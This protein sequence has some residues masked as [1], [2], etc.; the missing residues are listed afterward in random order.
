MNG[1]KFFLDTNA[2][3]AL[4][5]GNT[6][7]EQNLSEALWIGTSAICVLEFLSFRSLLKED[8]IIFDIFLKRIEVIEVPEEIP[9]LK[10]IAS[11]IQ[12]TRLKLPDAIIAAQAIQNNTVLISKDHHF[13]RIMD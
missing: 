6:T 10:K 2:I 9:T 13:N 4:L 3:I 7:I 12:D 1:I 11:F 8:K 5:N